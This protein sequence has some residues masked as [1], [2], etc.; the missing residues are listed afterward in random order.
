MNEDGEKP[1]DSTLN[2][3]KKIQDGE[4]NE[5]GDCTNTTKS[6]SPV[7]KNSEENTNTPD[8]NISGGENGEVLPSTTKDPAP[9]RPVINKRLTE[10]K[11][12]PITLS[13][14]ETK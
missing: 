10:S 5:N 12:D 6:E 2:E 4:N 13:W 11:L 1:K 7:D 9:S 3:D 14:E 8:P